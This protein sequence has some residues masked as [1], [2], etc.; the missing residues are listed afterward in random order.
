M[1][2]SRPRF[3]PH[4]FP[5]FAPTT[6]A[7]SYVSDFPLAGAHVY[8]KCSC[9]AGT[10]QSMSTLLPRHSH[11]FGPFAAAALLIVFW[12]V[13]LASLRGTSQTLDEGVHVTAGYTFWRYNDYRL[14]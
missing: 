2:S 5:R 13:M 11:L 1:G 4:Q 9:A 7:W 10:V 12:L 6:V 3:G 8:A 14:N